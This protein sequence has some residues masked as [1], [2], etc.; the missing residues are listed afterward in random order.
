MVNSAVP[1]KWWEDWVFWLVVIL[2]ISISFLHYTTVPSK[3]VIHDIY[4][5]LYYIPIIIAAFRYEWVGG[6]FSA[7]IITL[8]YLPHLLQQWSLSPAQGWNKLFEVILFNVVGILTGVLVTRQAEERR[9]YQN[10]AKKLDKSLKELQVQSKRLIETEEN[11]RIA[12]R[13]A[14]L[15]ELTASLAHEVRNPLGSIGGAA[16]LLAQDKLKPDEKQEVS[17]ILQKEV[18]RLN[19]VV[20]SYLGAARNDSRRTHTFQ[21]TEVVDSIQKLLAEKTRKKGIA[22]SIR[23]PSGSIT[24]TMDLNQLYQILLNILLNAVDAM[25]DGGTITL[26]AQIEGDDLHLQVYDEGIGMSPETL[27]HIWD[28]FYTTKQNGTG[29]GLPIVR[30]MV[31]EN[32][33]SITIQSEP[34][35]GTTVNIRL[36]M[37]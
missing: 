23:L 8:I 19:Q 15:G 30:R 17:E 20:E 2:I 7:G 11:L 3:G 18:D 14:V 4:R 22:F 16:R 34:N 6:V 24:L 9:R 25:P 28:T 32:D 35:K 10:T 5:R 12:D 26:I 37:G 21:L 13:L 33:G 29:L 36:P 27:D 31:D 1:D